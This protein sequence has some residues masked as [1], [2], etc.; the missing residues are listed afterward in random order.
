RI[1]PFDSVHAPPPPPSQR[2]ESIYRHPRDSRS[3]FLCLAEAYRDNEDGYLTHFKMMKFLVDQVGG[4]DSL[5]EHLK[6]GIIVADVYLA[7]E[8]IDSPIFA[9]SSSWD[10]GPLP[11]ETWS[12][13]TVDQTLSRLGTGFLFPK[14]IA[15]VTPALRSVI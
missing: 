5:E 9:S 7:A 15:V 13:L 10:P 12:R 4:L 1:D 3:V 6:V 2:A 11:L 8:R 14:E